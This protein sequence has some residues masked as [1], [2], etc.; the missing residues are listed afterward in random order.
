MRVR[1]QRS[2]AMDELQQTLTL[3]GAALAIGLL[4]GV[5]RGWQG[6]EAREGERVA[7]LRTYGLIGL[8]GGVTVLLA[9]YLGAIFVGLVFIGLAGLVTTSYLANRDKEGDIGITS[10]VVALL[11]FLLGALAVSGE[12]VIASS[13]AVV[14]TLLLSYK[15]L[16]HRWLGRIERT[17]LRA[18]IKLLL[19]SV[20]LLPIL[21]NQGYGPWGVLNPYA[22][23]WM[24]VMIA[25][26]STVGYFAVKIGGA[27]RGAL[28]TG[29]FG[30]L[31]SSTALT[32]HFSR[33]A[34]ANAKLNLALAMGILLACGTMFPRMLLVAS[35]LNPALFLPLLV[36]TVVMA[37]IVYVPA[38]VYWNLQT[39]RHDG[40]AFPLRNPLELGPALG[41]GLLLAGVLLLGKALQLWLGDAGVLALAAASGITDVDAIT[42]S[43]ARMSSHDLA[44]GVA[45]TGVVVAGAFNSF[46]KAGIATVVGG[47]DIGLRVG[48]PLAASGVGGLLAA[49]IWTW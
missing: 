32:L 30:G 21:P 42:L 46:A 15:P 3:L 9:D 27:R 16:L 47:R 36:P 40:G 13:S 6:R 44:L 2:D 48:V 45:V 14:A 7:G 31:A 18:G 10:L 33:T 8:L 28:F 1:L 17:E 34:R 49:L 38:I 25:A 29:L 41:F 19:I 4:I 43:L 11:T 35:I 5:E 26:I 20:V 12:V 37:L 39:D 23:W 22:I 24:V